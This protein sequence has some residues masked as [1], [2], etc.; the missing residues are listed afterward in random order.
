MF[1]FLLVLI[2]AVPIYFVFTRRKTAEM[3]PRSPHMILM[4]LIYLLT[5]SLG[6]T[7]LFSIDTSENTKQFYVCYIGVFCTVV[8]Q[9]GIMTTVFLRMFRIYSVFSAYE[10]YLKWQKENILK[11]VYPVGSPI[12]KNKHLS[13][14]SDDSP[15]F[16]HLTTH[17]SSSMQRSTNQNKEKNLE[18]DSSLNSIRQDTF[19]SENLGR[20]GNTSDSILNRSDRERR[21]ED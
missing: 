9:F 2:Y 13:Q 4:Y 5:D 14:L 15:R 12:A 16:K 7:I 17:S 8:C 21:M 19:E 3:T 1:M 18:S 6:N 20:S 11:D 10:D